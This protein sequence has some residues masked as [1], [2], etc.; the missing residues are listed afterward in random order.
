MHRTNYVEKIGSGIN[1][2]KKLIREYGLEV[3]FEVDSDWFRI[4][5]YRKLQRS[6]ADEG[7]NEGLNEGLK[8]LLN[9][10]KNNHGI[11][12]KDVSELLNKPI[13][14]IE[15]HIKELTQKELIERRGSKK[16]GGYY[17]K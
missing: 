15:R 7:L 16:T 4:I 5:F 11:K 13:K 6:K 3:N 8:T 9:L 2:I 12:A 10:I 14:T 17:I 1:R